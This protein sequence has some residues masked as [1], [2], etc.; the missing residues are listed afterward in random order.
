MKNIIFIGP[1]GS[2]KGTQTRQLAAA[3]Q[4]PLISTGA[5]LRKEVQQETPI[6]RDIKNDLYS[7][8]LAPDDI[9]NKMILH[10]LDDTGPN[11]ILDGYPRNI[12]QARTIVGFLKEKK[13]SMIIFELKLP[14]RIAIERI[15]G[16]RTCGCGRVYH[17]VYDPP[18]N[19]EIC[20]V[21]GRK[22]AI[23]DDQRPSVV[24]NRLDLYHDITEPM[25]KYLQ[26][27]HD[28]DIEYHQID[29]TRD[30]N[31]VFKDITSKI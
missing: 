11:F 13:W 29:S 27:Q 2:G 5:L 1:P 15:S 4:L 22:L 3:R 20:D 26:S 31:D 12:N 10:I 30:I 8:E 7:G 28:I 18:K 9:V 23:R 24:K 25:I 21:C 16:R 14:D 19:D 6:G 17:L